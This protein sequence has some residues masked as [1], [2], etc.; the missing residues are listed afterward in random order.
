MLGLRSHT[1]MR[2]D[3]ARRHPQGCGLVDAAVVEGIGP[4]PTILGMALSTGR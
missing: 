1:L 3:E 4:V 2:T